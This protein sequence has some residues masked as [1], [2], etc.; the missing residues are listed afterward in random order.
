MK[1]SKSMKVVECRQQYLKVI[2][3]I[4]G[5][6]IASQAGAAVF[7][8][9]GGTGGGDG[10]T[11]S[12]LGNWT[13]ASGPAIVP[14]SNPLTELRFDNSGSA[15]TVVNL[16]ATKAVGKINYLGTGST[17]YNII[18]LDS[19]KLFA[20]AGIAGTGIVNDSS[21]TQEID[22]NISLVNSQTWSANSGAL[23]LGGTIGIGTKTL[24][25][26]G[27]QNIIFGSAIA[28]AGSGSVI[29]SGSGNVTF[30]AA[31]TFNGGVTVNSGTLTLAA[32][33]ATGTGSIILGGGTLATSGSRAVDNTITG[34]GTLTVPASDVLTLSGPVSGTLT[35]AGAGILELSGNNNTFTGMTLTAGTLALGGASSGIMPS[36]AALTLNGGTFAARNHTET[37]GALTLAASSVLQLQADATPGSL[38]FASANWTAG[39]LTIKGWSGVAN[40]TTPSTPG[41]DDRVFISSAPAADFLSNVNFEGYP[42]GG[43]M[44]DNELVP[45]PEPHQYAMLIGFGL[46][47][48][49]ACRRLNR[50]T[51]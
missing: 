5:S 37:M 43:K 13:P 3:L 45:V 2:A 23:V 48:F 20:I 35:K 18:A 4:A 39:V 26:A 25:L 21:V 36:G 9:N 27:A 17:A 51:A 34:T 32:D 38:T 49:A 10:F 41:T 29:L 22:A 42:S 33:Q 7:T 16:D 28:G 14:P 12:D 19:T 50:K 40:L 8:W 6:I 24:T 47:G 31:S 30:G 46:M 1:N 11:Y 15:G 44:L